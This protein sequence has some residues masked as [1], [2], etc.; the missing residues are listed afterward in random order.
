MER[1]A[2]LGDGKYLDVTRALGVGATET[3]DSV[4]DHRLLNL[5]SAKNSAAVAPAAINQPKTAMNSLDAA[6][7]HHI[8]AALERT[9]GRIEGPYG[10]AKVLG[11]NPHTLRARMRKMQIEWQRFREV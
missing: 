8:E 10:A 6:M 7:K 4:H 9:R 1:A 3:D 2:I 11:I 5:A